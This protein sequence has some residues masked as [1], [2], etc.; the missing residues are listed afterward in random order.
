VGVLTTACDALS[1]TASQHGEASTQ[2]Q[3]ALQLFLK[4]RVPLVTG[5]QLIATGRS[6]A[7]QTHRQTRPHV[8][9]PPNQTQHQMLL[10]KYGEVAQRSVLERLVDA[11]TRSAPRL[12][13]LGL[14]AGFLVAAK[15]EGEA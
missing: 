7:A 1:Y 10:I 3:G 8:T 15:G 5:W 6:P 4:V 12:A 9:P 14:D 13:A 2:A 11:I